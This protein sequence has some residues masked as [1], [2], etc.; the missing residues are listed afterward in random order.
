MRLSKIHFKEAESAPLSLKQ[1]RYLRQ[2]VQKRYPEYLGLVDD[3][4]ENALVGTAGSFESDADVL[5]DFVAYA[6]YI[7][8]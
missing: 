6:K 5:K 1:E 4:I 8:G 3:Y 7:M 2:T